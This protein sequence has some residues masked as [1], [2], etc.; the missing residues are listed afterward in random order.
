MAVCPV[1]YDFLGSQQLA[2]DCFGQML[3]PAEE[4]CHLKG[5]A[6]VPLSLPPLKLGLQTVPACAG[7]S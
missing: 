1:T 3:W 7:K 4:S 6:H 2:K 5:Q